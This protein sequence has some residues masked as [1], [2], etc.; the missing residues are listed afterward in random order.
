MLPTIIFI[1]IENI[2]GSWIGNLLYNVLYLDFSNY[3]ISNNY[4]FV[5]FKLQKVG[6]TDKLAQHKSTGVYK[7]RL[8]D[9]FPLF[10]SETIF[11]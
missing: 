8:N 5:D 11:H 7:V 4:E 10:I 6:N 2:Y 3:Y 9:S 1:E